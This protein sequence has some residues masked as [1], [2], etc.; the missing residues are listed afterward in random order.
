[1]IA[2]DL[3]SPGILTWDIKRCERTKAARTALA[4]PE[5][6]LVTVEGG[7]HLGVAVHLAVPACA[8]LAGAGLPHLPL[9]V[10]HPRVGLAGPG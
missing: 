9:L 3:F 8:A 1:M 10:H 4:L 5:D 7:T 6:C 2:G